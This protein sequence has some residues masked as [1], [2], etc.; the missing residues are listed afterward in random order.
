MQLDAGRCCEFTSKAEHVSACGYTGV[1]VSLTLRGGNTDNGQEV[2]VSRV[3]TYTWASY[4]S[5]SPSR[6]EVHQKDGQY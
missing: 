6:K 5:P 1:H 2:T 3:D 4:P